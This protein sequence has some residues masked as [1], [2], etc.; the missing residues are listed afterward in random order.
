MKLRIDFPVPMPLASFLL[1]THAHGGHSLTLYA[2]DGTSITT[3]HGD[4]W[5]RAFGWASGLAKNY[6]HAIY[7]GFEGDYEIGWVRDISYTLRGCEPT[8]T[9]SS[10]PTASETGTPSRT[11]VTRTPGTPGTAT[12]TPLIVQSPTASA[13]N[14]SA[15]PVT[16]ASTPTP[17]PTTSLVPL[18]TW[19]PTIVPSNDPVAGTWDDAVG[20]WQ[21][22]ADSIE[23]ENDF[24][25]LGT[26]LAQF[27]NC[28]V[29]PVV[30]NIQNALAGLFD[31]IGNTATKF[32]EWLGSMLGWLAGTLNNFGGSLGGAF[33]VILD[34]FALIGRFIT[35]IFDIVGLLLSIIRHLLELFVGW[36]G[37]FIE[38]IQTILYDWYLTTPKPIPYLPQ[39][40]S[41]PTASDVCAVYYIL[42]NTLLAGSV[43]ALLIPFIVIVIDL[44]ILMRFIIAVRNLINKG[45]GITA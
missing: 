26:F 39:C 9:P 30:I 41:N 28:T 42:E 38:L 10:T 32:F 6:T 40:L 29:M 33:Q 16:P 23:M 34:L 37:Q 19:L 22:C 44:A 18:P 24:L 13:V 35:D 12:S 2:T 7:T 4:P 36:I 17:L 31:W 43:G 1:T 3:N 45:E 11:P 21:D 14:P 27:W 5:E 15:T 20:E 8:P 25:G